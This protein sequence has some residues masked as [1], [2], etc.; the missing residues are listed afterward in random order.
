MMH[1]IYSSNVLLKCSFS[2]DF[3]AKRGKSSVKH[4]ENTDELS[5]VPVKEKA[6]QAYTERLS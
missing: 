6:F 3:L 1:L 4:E 5:Y 2:Y